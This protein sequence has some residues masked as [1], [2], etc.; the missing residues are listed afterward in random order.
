MKLTE[1]Y[2]SPLLRGYISRYWSWQE[3]ASLPPLLPGCGGE[4]FFYQRP[5]E[6]TR[7]GSKESERKTSALL[8]PRDAAF[9]FHAHAPISFIAVRFRTGALR[10]FCPLAETELI[11][12]SLSPPEVWGKSAAELEQRLWETPRVD[13]K[14]Q[15][16]ERFLLRQ[17][18]L[19]R[20]ERHVWL[21]EAARRM[22][23]QC[24]HITQRDLVELSGFGERYFQKTFKNH[25]GVAPRHFQ[26]IIRVEQLTRHLLLHRQK[27]YL[28]AAL[29]YGYYDQS[30]FIKDFRFFIGDTPSRFLQ[31]SNFRS[32]FYNTPSRQNVS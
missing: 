25:F 12:V 30:H 26:R 16:I 21:D 6:I 3:E 27:D 9:R 19:N 7:P 4:M 11:D 2:P 18:T 10:H 13:D 31:E 32:H 15:M 14:V 1:L 24:N 28:S 22:Y 5:V 20:K 23:Y 8:L 17:L 29:E